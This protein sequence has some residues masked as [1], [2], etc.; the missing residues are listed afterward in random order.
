MSSS[1]YGA[2]LVFVAAAAVIRAVGILL[3]TV[4]QSRYFARA[5]AKPKSAADLVTAP[6]PP[7]LGLVA[8]WLLWTLDLRTSPSPSDW[9]LAVGAAVAAASGWGL[10]L[11][12]AASFP[13]VSPGHYILPEQKLV[14]TGAYAFVRNPLYAGALLVWFG[15]AAAYSSPVVLAITLLYVLP[16]YWVYMR[17]EER[18]LLSY[19]GEPYARYCARVGMFWPRFRPRSGSVQR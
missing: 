18:M 8:M 1:I 7:L 12:A 13:A 15:L 9:V 19:F 14:T 4:R 5:V 2:L 3:L 17:S 6:E 10:I 16:G 11:W